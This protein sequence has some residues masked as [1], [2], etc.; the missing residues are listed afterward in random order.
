MQQQKNTHTHTNKNE[1]D[2]SCS[3]L[4]RLLWRLIVAALCLFPDSD[5]AFF[6]SQHSS[7]LQVGGLHVLLPGALH[8]LGALAQ[9]RLSST[10]EDLAWATTAPDEKGLGGLDSRDL[11]G[12]L[13]TRE[14]SCEECEAAPV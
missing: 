3:A 13:E 5:R 1:N 2:T 9:E 7:V 8:K 4:L 12:G 11:G 14:S 6:P 10:I